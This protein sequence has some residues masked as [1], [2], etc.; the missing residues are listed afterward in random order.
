[1]GA[2]VGG[3]DVG[4]RSRGL[5]GSVCLR[6]LLRVPTEVKEAGVPDIAIQES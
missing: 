1:M 5:V 4:A 3:T 6:C 2:N